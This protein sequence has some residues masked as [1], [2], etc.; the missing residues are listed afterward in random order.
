LALPTG[1]NLNEIGLSK[2]QPYATLAF[3]GRGRILSDDARAELVVGFSPGM[4]F[5]FKIKEQVDFKRVIIVPFS[6]KPLLH[7]YE[8]ARLSSD[9]TL[10]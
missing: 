4:N 5:G 9:R 2:V 6:G 8:T 10:K 7:G 3:T 1:D